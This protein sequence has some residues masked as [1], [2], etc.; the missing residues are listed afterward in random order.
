MQIHQIN[1]SE[2][3]PY[4]KNP[5][6]N[7]N[8]VPKVADSI[9]Q[10]GFKVPIV[11]DSNNVIVA[12]HTRY[13]AAQ[14]LGIEQVPCIIADDLSQEQIRA[15]RLADNKVAEFAEWDFTALNEELEALADFD[16]QSFGFV[17]IDLHDDD[18]SDFFELPET[19]KDPKIKT[20]T[21]PHCGEVFEL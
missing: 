15:Y 20:T 6:L 19:P 11:I 4:D 12:G 8:A 21:C 2:L 17:N 5:R 1:I 14:Q 9:R 16:M 7:D 13:K 10:F 3:T 18:L